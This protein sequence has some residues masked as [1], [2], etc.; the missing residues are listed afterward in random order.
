MPR[1]MTRLLA[2]RGIT[3][4]AVAPDSV[5]SYHVYA[6]RVPHRDQV[7]ERLTAAGV[8]TLIHYPQGRSVSSAPMPIKNTPPKIFPSP[9]A[10]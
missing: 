8:E 5:H 7:R 10:T 6:V 1:A 2:K 3:P 4:P 9:S